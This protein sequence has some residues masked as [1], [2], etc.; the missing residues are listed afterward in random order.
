MTSFL[1]VVEPGM[2]T[3]VQDLG[4]LRHQCLGVPVAGALDPLSLRLANTLVGNPENAG[5]L[6]IRIVGPTL[7]VD[8]ASVRVAV[9]GTVHP[10]EILD[11]PIIRVEPGESIRLTRG[12]TF[13]IGMTR[14]TSCCYLAVEGGFSLP[15]PF[16]SQSTYIRG[17][18]GGFEGRP[19]RKGD[20]VPLAA[21]EVPERTERR[22]G[23]VPHIDRPAPIRVVLGPQDDYF[24]EGAIET[25]LTAEFTIS[26]DADR[27]GLRLEGPVIEHRKGYNITSDGI[28]TGSIQVPGTGR[29][30]VLLADHQTTGGYP[31][32]AT[33]VSSDLP[34]LG[35]M[36]PGGKLRFEAMNVADA[37]NTRRDQ[38][39]AIRRLMESIVPV[40]GPSEP[41]N[42]R[43]LAANL[44]SGVFFDAA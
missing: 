21:A 41:D 2:C 10:L 13:R 33:V 27:M 44:I 8:A 9:A 15:A 19:L 35:R 23:D 34:R 30:I 3:T 6:E 42:A 12:Q 25:F 22:L 31:K 32:I 40:A 18:F 36:R 17:G 39:R 37:E 26:R 20:D 43:L 38:E 11:E 16:G 24:T 1:H 29:P 5:A 4:R 28:A 7:R 14:D